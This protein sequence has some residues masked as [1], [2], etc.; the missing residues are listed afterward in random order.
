MK[1]IIVESPSKIRTIQGF[2]DKSYKVCA[3]M[4]HTYRIIP[5]SDSI[6]IENHYEPKY[7]VI[8]EKSK[9]VSEI[10]ALAKKAEIVYIATDPDREGEA[11]GY[12]MLH[13]ALR[14]IK[15]PIKRITFNSITKSEVLSA[16]KN[17]RNIDLNL[18]HAQQARA[19]LDMLVGFGVS[20]SLISK[21]GSNTSAG[22]VQSI[23][24]ELIVERQK[25]IDAFVK[26]EYWDI[27]GKF[28][29]DKH[30]SFTAMYSSKDKLTNKEQTKKVASEIEKEDK[31]NIESISKDTKLRSPAP[32]FNTSSLQ[33]TCY[34][35]WG[36]DN[37]KTM[38][39]AQKLY[40]GFS[41]NGNQ[42][43]GLISYMRTDSFNIDP[44]SLKNVRDTILNKYGSTYLSKT[45]RVFKSKNKAEQ[46]GHSG[47]LCPHLDYT[48]D[49]VRQSVPSDEAKLYEAIYSRF[50]ACQMSDAA[51][52]TSKVTIKSGSNKH[53]FVANGQTMNFDGYLKVWTYSTAK[54]E[55]L[56]E[57]KEKEVVFLE[58]I[59]PQQHYTQG[60]PRLNPGSLTKEMEALSV[61][62][63]STY[64][65]VVEILKKRLFVDL[66]EKAFVPTE[67]GKKVC[68]FLQGSFPELMNVEYTAKIEDKLDDCAEGKAV[69]YEVVDG[70]YKE[71]EKRLIE[72]KS[73]PSMRTNETTDITCPTCGKYKLIKKSG[74]FGDFYG[75]AG[76]A[77][78]KKCKAT[79]KINPEDQKP[80]VIPKVE[81][82]YLEG[83]KCDKCGSKMVIR[84]SKKTGKQF[85]G[86]EKF[87]ACRFMCDLEGKPIVF[88]KKNFKKKKEV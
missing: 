73:A 18:Y 31:W 2:V 83:V 28:Q 86:C 27:T 62:R 12:D 32:L 60:P 6:D 85:S 37:K 46:A 10:K 82:V 35:M 87:P 74:R 16:L 24:L 30:K 69:W 52:D 64:A 1:L 79:F 71:L 43:T 19:V 17:P 72:A 50:V 29:T 65:Y 49:I 53:T 81:K 14:D 63:P 33:Q 25:E 70:F 76:Y 66:S 47:I 9:V 15:C 88:K 40:E 45:P 11:I 77:D 34:S 5:K 57:V 75:C 26:E 55:L 21:V 48:P 51:F 84:T 78:K 67:I 80:L 44:E 39:V 68:T 13:R 23:G 22:R 42:S 38:S 20:K 36:W 4:G 58:S 56:P 54:E 61:G 8:P 7:E 3:S 59:E 41:I